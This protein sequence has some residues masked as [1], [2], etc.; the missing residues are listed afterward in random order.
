MSNNYV[1]YSTFG[2]AEDMTSDP[3]T[4]C[5]VSELD[6]SFLHGNGDTVPNCNSLSCQEYMSSLWAQH[7]NTND[8][9]DRLCYRYFLANTTP[10]YMPNLVNRWN[11]CNSCDNTNRPFSKGEILL[12]NAARK[13]YGS[14][15]KNWFAFDP[16]SPA[17]PYVYSLVGPVQCTVDPKVIDNDK[18][19]DL[20]L[21]NPVATMD[22]LVN[23]SNSCKRLGINLEGTKIGNFQRQYLDHVSS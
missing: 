10:S 23:I 17:S 7:A 16:T 9:Y 8:Q 15:Q 6:K 12:R 11:L 14:G 13:R 5:F 1:Q 21:R 2:G 3:I 18:F 4:Y 22:V 20:C 19:M